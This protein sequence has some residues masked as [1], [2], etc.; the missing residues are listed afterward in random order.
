MTLGSEGLF[1]F[2]SS[3]IA[4]YRRLF[5]LLLLLLY[6][7]DKMI[8]HRHYQMSYILSHIYSTDLGISILLDVKVK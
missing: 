1:R 5:L 2:L 8:Y 3:F 6:D 4:F 7:R